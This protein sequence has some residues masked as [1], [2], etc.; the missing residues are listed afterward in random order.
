[1]YKDGDCECLSKYSIGRTRV[2]VA[3]VTLRTASCTVHVVLLYIHVLCTSTGSST[4]PTPGRRPRAEWRYLDP[5]FP[6][7][8]ARYYV[9]ELGLA[10]SLFR[11]L[12]CFLS[13]HSRAVVGG[14]EG[15]KKHLK[16]HTQYG[17]GPCCFGA[18]RSLQLA[19]LAGRA[20]LP[21]W[22]RPH[23]A[24]MPAGPGLAGHCVQ[25]YGASYLYIVP[26]TE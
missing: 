15:R 7:C 19:W 25:A 22:P 24:T 13:I 23:W 1:M 16:R 17:V 6:L 11:F 14:E 26:S 4:S 3:L 12:P 21:A 2:Q 10:R 18:R 8:H 5:H 20:K 9:L